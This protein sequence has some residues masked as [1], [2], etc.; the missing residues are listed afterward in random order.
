MRSL[1]GRRTELELPTSTQQVLE[2]TIDSWAALE[3]GLAGLGT[4]DLSRPDAVGWWSLR[5]LTAH[6][7]ASNRWIAGQLDALRRNSPPEAVACLGSDQAPA[8]GV[9]LADNDSRNAWAQEIRR[10]WTLAQVREEYAWATGWFIAG[11]S[12]IPNDAWSVDYTI[13]EHGW[14]GQLRRWTPTDGSLRFSLAKLV[15]GY[16]W[17]HYAVHTEDVRRARQALG[18]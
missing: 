5:D 7:G 6:L 15:E 2:L 8:Q 17:E 3:R 10:D 14:V 11:S 18:I 16:A 9:D 12:R 1:S 13:A 4:A